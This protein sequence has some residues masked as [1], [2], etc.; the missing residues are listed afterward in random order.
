MKKILIIYF[1][2]SRFTLSCS[3]IR[4]SAGVNR[5]NIDEFKVI[6]NPPLVIPPNFNLL[7]PEQ[8]S[9]KNINKI[10]SRQIKLIKMKINK[11][12]N[13]SIYGSVYNIT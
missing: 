10:K 9:E 8:L 12:Y 3:Q 4:E 11:I 5:K 7:P 1:F 2:I 13:V 6:E